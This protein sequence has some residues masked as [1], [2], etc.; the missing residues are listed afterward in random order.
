MI[1]NNLSKIWETKLKKNKPPKYF[2][3]LRIIDF[4]KLKSSINDQKFC[5]KIIQIRY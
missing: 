4:E 3:K 2:R 5:A 1:R